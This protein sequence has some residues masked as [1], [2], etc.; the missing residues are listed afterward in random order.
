MNVKKIQFL[1]FAI[2]FMGCTKNENAKSSESE[3]FLVV[4]GI[5]QDAGYPQVNCTKSCCSK[6]WN[7][8]VR[9]EKVVSLGLVDRPHNKVYLFEATPDFKDQLHHLLEYLP[10]PDINSVG[11]IFLT[12][13]HMGHYTGLMELGHEA[14]GASNVPVYAMPKMQSYLEQ[15]GPWSQLV[16]FNNIEINPLLQDSSISL[17]ETIQIT[18]FLVP[19]RDEF[20]ETVG[21]KITA[22]DMNAL[23]IPDI[24]KWDKWERSIVDEVEKVNYAF[25]DATFYSSDELPGRDM[26]EIPHPFVPE[27]T[28]LFDDSADSIK[29][30][31]VLIH[32]NHTNP[33]IHNGD[34]YKNVLNAG[35]K[36]SR[37]GS[38]YPLD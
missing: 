6:V 15:N 18:P 22:N 17:N 26:S 8:E 13:A 1:L 3:V 38:K 25:L 32:F 23:F 5:A 28:A 30:K 14:M 36:V 24:N 19:H 31:I 35:Y 10:E 29:N 16:S 20:S 9:R 4:L 2:L 21:Y 11:G 7:G 33:L 12:H 34:A 27:T 37:E